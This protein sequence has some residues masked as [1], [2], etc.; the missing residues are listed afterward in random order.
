ML[1]HNTA[2]VTVEL[3]AVSIWVGSLVCLAVVANA[4]RSVLD[5]HT[6]IAFF[7]T[8]GRRYGVLGTTALLVAIGCGLMLSWP[9][10]SWPA[11]TQAAVGIGGALVIV[12]VVA[13]G[14]ARAMTTLRSHA[15]AAPGDRAMGAAVRRGRKI[16]DGLRGVMALLTLAVIVL[17][18]QAVTH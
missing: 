1:R 5:T 12:S 17:G 6:Q 11:V 14:Q 8:V 16:A 9:P 7:R 4:A 10:L 3:L 15:S 2:F 13:M 18:A